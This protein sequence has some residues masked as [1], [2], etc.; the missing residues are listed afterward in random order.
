MN[1]N[2]PKFELADVIRYFRVSL[3]E[4]GGV[5]SQQK[6]V[7]TNLSQCRTSILGYHLDL[8]DNPGCEH[9]HISYNS[10]RDRHCPKCNGLKREKW[11][12]MREE[13]LM[14]EKYYHAVFTVPDSLNGAFLQNPVECY[15][16]LFRS[17]WETIAKFGNDH[18]HLGAKMGMTAILHTWGQNLQYHPHVHCIVPGGGITKNGKWRSVCKNGKY[19]FPVK[20]MGK[21]FRGKFTDGLIELEKKK[22]VMLEER[23]DPCK[24]YLHP[25]YKKK[26]VVYAKTPMPDASHV[27]NYIG[28]Y[29]HR[30]AISNH[31]IKDIDDKTVTFSYFDYRTSKTGTISLKGEDFLQRFILHVL[32][33]GFMKIRHYGILSS[34]AKGEALK[35]ARTEFGI[36]PPKTIKGLPWQEVFLIV[37]GHHPLLCPICKQ[38]KMAR[39]HSVMPQNR[40][41]PATLPPNTDFIAQ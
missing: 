19:L 3:E 28:R 27:V 5:A 18:R 40:G 34:R 38:G 25:L 26:W 37:Y 13:D 2:R 23:F 22:M 8:C 11:V 36:E 12:R 29:S 9:Q 31:R 30:I 39:V 1:Y 10:C 15:N 14:P 16:L 20:A 4:K 17:A 41:S 21:V 6:K 32:P 24:K 35:L 7:M 33:A